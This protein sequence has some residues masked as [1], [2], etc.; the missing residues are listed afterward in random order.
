[1]KRRDRASGL[2]LWVPRR[3]HVHQHDGR[4]D[5]TCGERRRVHRPDRPIRWAACASRRNGGMIRICFSARR[6]KR[7][8]APYFRCFTVW[9]V[10]DHNGSWLFAGGVCCQIDT[11]PV[12]R[13]HQK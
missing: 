5:G 4:G 1:M 2:R 10:L 11:A 6:I 7:C 8:A 13:S 12:L 3:L 9:I